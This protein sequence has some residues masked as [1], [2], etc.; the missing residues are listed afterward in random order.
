MKVYSYNQTVMDT[1][2]HPEFLEGYTPEHHVHLGEADGR[3]F[4]SYDPEFVK[5]AENDEEK[6]AVKEY[7]SSKKADKAEL[8]AVANKLHFLRQV[9]IG[10][11]AALFDAVDMF[12]VLSGI[13]EQD[14]YILNKIKS[15]KQDVED[16]LSSYGF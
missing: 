11:K 6:Y 16:T 12:D 14:K 4:Y 5:L 1:F 15:V 10:K 8:A 13:A 9:I 3:T 7:D 2:N